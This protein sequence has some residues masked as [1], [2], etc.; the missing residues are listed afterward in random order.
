MGPTLLDEI[1]QLKIEVH[2]MKN[3]LRDI[4]KFLKVISTEL[5]EIN[6]KNREEAAKYHN[7]LITALTITTSLLITD[8]KPK[9]KDIKKLSVDIPEQVSQKTSSKKIDP[10]KPV[11]LVKPIEPQKS[12]EEIP[13]KSGEEI[14][15]KSDEEIP[16][17]IRKVVPIKLIPKNSV[18][19]KI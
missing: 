1:N 3:S 5:V 9:I 12:V 15:R 7:S 6:K 4:N 10:V 16:K 2:D 13:R 17:K 8:H 11:I 18:K 14:P 19:R